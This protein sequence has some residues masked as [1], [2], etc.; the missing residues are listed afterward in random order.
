MKKSTTPPVDK[1]VEVL[2]A[3]FF[4]TA[5]DE[6]DTQLED[7]VRLLSRVDVELAKSAATLRN[8]V[9]KQMQ[10]FKSQIRTGGTS[11]DCDD[12]DCDCC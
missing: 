3:K 4:F 7:A 12:D 8:A 9:K 10:D 6:A 5:L 2:R 11:C 1:E